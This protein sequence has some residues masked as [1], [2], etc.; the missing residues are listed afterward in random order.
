VEVDRVSGSIDVDGLIE[1]VQP[2]A[3]STGDPGSGE[4]PGL[5]DLDQL[6]ESLVAAGFELSASGDDGRMERFDL[7]LSLD[8]PE[9]SL[10]PSRIRFSLTDPGTAG[11]G[12]G[13]TPE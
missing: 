3:S 9:N 13:G 12:T 5:G 10:P 7:I 8:D 6:S 1:A 11:S 2:L 4:V